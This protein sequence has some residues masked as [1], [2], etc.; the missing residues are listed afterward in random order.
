MSDDADA[1][2]AFLDFCNNHKLNPVFLYDLRKIF[3]IAKI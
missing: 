3:G 1:S 2:Y